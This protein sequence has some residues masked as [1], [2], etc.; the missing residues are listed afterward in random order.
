M[1]IYIFIYIYNLD[2]LSFADVHDIIV[3]VA[4]S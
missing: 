3:E 4:C 1:Y 2:L